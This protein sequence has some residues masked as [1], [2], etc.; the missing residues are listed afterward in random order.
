LT[1]YID[2]SSFPGFFSQNINGD[3]ASVQAFEAHVAQHLRISPVPVVA[4]I[5]FWK[6]YSQNLQRANKHANEVRDAI[7]LNNGILLLRDLNAFVDVPSRN[8]LS[9]LIAG[10]GFTAR[11]IAVASSIL[12]FA[13]PKLFPIVDVWIARW[14]NQYWEDH[15]V[16]LSGQPRIPLLCF[17]GGGSIAKH[18]KYFTVQLR[19]FDAYTQWVKWSH[20]QGRILASQQPLVGWR[21]RDVE[22][23]VFAAARG[24]WL[25]PVL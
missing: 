2:K 3:R 11:N 7:S 18:P 16:R 8:N 1:G 9:N 15:S 22:M 10:L 19:H 23:A 17:Q 21:C 20:E 13:Y 5:V 4:E 12:A 14:V 24:G 25:L 6:I